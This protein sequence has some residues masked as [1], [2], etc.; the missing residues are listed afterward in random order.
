MKLRRLLHLLL[1]LLGLLGLLP[2]RLQ[3]LGTHEDREESER[4]AFL[5]LLGPN[6]GYCFKDTGR[7]RNA[8]LQVLQ[9]CGELRRSTDVSITAVRPA[10]Y[11][12]SSCA[13]VYFTGIGEGALLVSMV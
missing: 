9:R 10:T 1:D 3:P 5:H 11:V 7:C 8:R 12:I 6:G 4:H 13:G 2:G